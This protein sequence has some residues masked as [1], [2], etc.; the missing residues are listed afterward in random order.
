MDIN[1][2]LNLYDKERIIKWVLRKNYT[3][4]KNGIESNEIVKGSK[5][6]AEKIGVKDIVVFNDTAE[7]DFYAILAFADV[8]V[9][10]DK[11]DWRL[12][13]VEEMKTIIMSEKERT[14]VPVRIK[15]FK[16]KVYEVNYRYN[17][18]WKFYTSER[19]HKKWIQMC[20]LWF[21]K[22]EIYRKDPEL[23]RCGR[24]CLVRG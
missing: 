18:N 20:E 1:E 10:E 8:F 13:T 6:T 14:D 21:D 3:I 22:V 9:F 5:D 4:T 19:W 15:K 17:F 23:F 16:D 24:F 11:K 7:S 2:L 12:P